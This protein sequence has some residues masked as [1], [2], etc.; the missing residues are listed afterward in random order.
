MTA[1]KFLVCSL[2]K[3]QRT[4]IEKQPAENEA[5][6]LTRQEK[7]RLQS[8]KNRSDDFYGLPR[9]RERA[10]A[11]YSVVKIIKA[12]ARTQY[13]LTW[14][15]GWRFHIYYFPRENHKQKRLRPKKEIL[16]DD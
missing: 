13:I 1:A 7:T 6:N 3:Q 10:T 5:I 9:K 4:G 16:P 15:L 11:P 14:A 8:N 12:A 2:L